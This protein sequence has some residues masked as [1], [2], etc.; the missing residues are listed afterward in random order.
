MPATARL[1]SLDLS[2]PGMCA[3]LAL[4]QKGVDYRLTNLPAGMHPVLVRAAGFKRPTVPALR[5]DGRRVQ[6]S[7]EITAYLEETR[8]SPPLFGKTPA[9]RAAIFE[10]EAW[11]ESELQ[12][13]PRRIFRFAA[14]TEDDVTLWLAR[15]QRMPVAKLAAKISRP[16]AIRLAGVVGATRERV[17]ADVEDLPNTLDR[18]DALIADGVIGGEHPNAADMQIL[19][20]IRSLMS[21]TD[22]APLIA[23][24]PAAVAAERLVPAFPGPLPVWMPHEWVRKA[25]ARSSGTSQG[26]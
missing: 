9:E 2:H 24:R 15:Q 21:I 12:P 8:P 18:V 22:V 7:R 19:T 17:Q 14:S 6:G 23:G 4:R 26:R 25:A 5:I 13:L 16:V 3:Q 20:T 11:G 1:Y 10:A